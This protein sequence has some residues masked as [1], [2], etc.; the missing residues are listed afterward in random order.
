MILFFVSFFF[1]LSLFHFDSLDFIISPSFVEASGFFHSFGNEV[2][3]WHCDGHW[4]RRLAKPQI[5]TVLCK[6]L[7]FKVTQWAWK[8]QIYFFWE[9]WKRTSLIEI[10]HF[11]RGLSPRSGWI[12]A[13][14]RTT[15]KFEP[16]FSST[17]SVRSF[18]FDFNG[19]PFDR[20]KTEERKPLLSRFFMHA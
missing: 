19:F 16:W 6:I 10:L 12:V 4:I 20:I 17:V 9:L 1:I 11:D 5:L 14:S 18:Q 15:I 7:S 8:V 13:E 3:G 2:Q